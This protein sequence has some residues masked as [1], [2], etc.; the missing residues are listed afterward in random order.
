MVGIV[1]L[2]AGGDP[3][4]ACNTSK[5]RVRTTGPPVALCRL[6]THDDNSGQVSFV[7]SN[8]SLVVAGVRGAVSLGPV[9]ARHSTG[10]TNEPE[11]AQTQ[12]GGE[13]FHA[14]PLGVWGRYS[15]QNKPRRR[16]RKF[17]RP[18]L[19]GVRGGAGGQN[20]CFSPYSI[21]LFR[22]RV[23]PQNWGFCKIASRISGSHSAIATAG[24]GSRWHF[25]C[26][27]N[28]QLW[29]ITTTRRGRK[30]WSRWNARTAL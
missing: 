9:Y 6:T 11:S 29:L 3:A 19:S 24:S 21:Y 7:C 13:T 8:N 17:V 18:A 26:S 12:S 28:T 15:R 2:K 4:A 14:G 25:F 1:Y 30:C 23:R 16:K 22:T 10:D 5:E 27:R 20:V